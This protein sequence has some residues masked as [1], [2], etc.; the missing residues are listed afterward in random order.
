MGF[1]RVPCNSI[2]VFSMQV[3][4][5]KDKKRRR[6]RRYQVSGAPERMEHM[7]ATREEETK[8]EVFDPATKN[9]PSSK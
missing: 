5:K 8:E 2:L 1:R 6:G 3:V 7:Q 4:E 9:P